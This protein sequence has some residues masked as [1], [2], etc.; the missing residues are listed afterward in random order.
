MSKRK[1][2]RIKG[3]R[4]AETAEGQPNPDAVEVAIHKKQQV[5]RRSR[6]L[7][8]IRTQGAEVADQS[9]EG[10]PVAESLGLPDAHS[11]RPLPSEI[12]RTK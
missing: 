2:D 11:I 7:R 1:G 12:K 4:R 9:D 8:A 3:G 6:N 5:Q 10:D